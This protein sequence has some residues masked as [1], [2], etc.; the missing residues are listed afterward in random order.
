MYGYD[1]GEEGEDEEGGGGGG[2]GRG[3]RR[4]RRRRRSRGIRF[5][6]GRVLALNNPSTYELQLEQTVRTQTPRRWQWRV[7]TGASELRGDSPDVV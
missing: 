2:R 1:E 5:I 4:R 6:V 3:R 7:C